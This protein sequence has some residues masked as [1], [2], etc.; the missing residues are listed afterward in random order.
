MFQLKFQLYLEYF[1]FYLL[2]KTLIIHLTV[3]GFHYWSRHL[4]DFKESADISTAGK[5]VFSIQS[6]QVTRNSPDGKCIPH[7][8]VSLLYT[9]W[10]LYCFLGRY[11]FEFMCIQ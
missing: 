5:N 2:V 6:D 9:V 4:E 10:P 1:A 8:I 11:T 7:N 3:H